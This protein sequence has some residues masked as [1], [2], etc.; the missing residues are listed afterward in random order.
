MDKEILNTKIKQLADD[1]DKFS[2][3]KKEL[4]NK[5]IVE[6]CAK[7]KDFEK[8][9][10]VD[11]LRSLLK[12]RLENEYVISEFIKAGL[13][14]DFVKTPQAIEFLRGSKDG[15]GVLAT[16]LRLFSGESTSTTESTVRVEHVDISDRIDQLRG[17]LGDN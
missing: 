17:R 14:H 6:I 9:E 16:T 2:D 12:V 13:D 8:G 10:I 7:I 3:E 11:N 4:L 1:Y 5:S 15:I